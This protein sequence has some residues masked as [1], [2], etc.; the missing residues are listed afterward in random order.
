MAEVTKEG[1]VCFAHPATVEQWKKVMRDE[2]FMKVL[3]DTL[4]FYGGT[5]SSYMTCVTPQKGEEGGVVGFDYYGYSRGFREMESDT[6]C[7]AMNISIHPLY[8]PK[9]IICETAE[10]GEGE[11]LS[12][13]TFVTVG[14]IEYIWLNKN[15]CEKG[16][17]YLMD[18]I[19]FCK[20]NAVPYSNKPGQCDYSEATRLQAQC[21][22]VAL[23][24]CNEEEMMLLQK[25]TLKQKDNY[26][27]GAGWNCGISSIPAIYRQVELGLLSADEATKQIKQ[28][29]EQIEFDDDA[30]ET[31]FD[32]IYDEYDETLPNLNLGTISGAE[33]YIDKARKDVTYVEMFSKAL[34]RE[35]SDYLV[36][37]DYVVEHG[38]SLR[39]LDWRKAHAKLEEIRTQKPIKNDYNDVFNDEMIDVF[40]EGRAANNMLNKQI[41]DLKF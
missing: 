33:G 27:L 21:E 5:T 7:N 16:A 37:R 8:N 26:E 2:R 25:V 39:D 1:V 41:D 18:L 24:N 15:E 31:W 11:E 3:V 36:R 30:Y 4:D 13:W 38:K 12:A 32:N 23:R 40:E 35:H 34:Q 28:S 9:S 19:S 29:A 10:K 6:A 20:W 14:G 22:Q 17:S